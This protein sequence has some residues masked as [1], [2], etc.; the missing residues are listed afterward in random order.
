MIIAR[1]PECRYYMD[2]Y[3]ILKV[4]I[5]DIRGGKYRTIDDN[6]GRIYIGR[7]VDTPEVSHVEI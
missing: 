2:Y 3:N 5:I 7:I 4:K 1:E 6:E